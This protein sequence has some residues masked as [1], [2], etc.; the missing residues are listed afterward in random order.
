MRTETSI[1]N[2]FGTRCVCEETFDDDGRSI[3]AKVLRIATV[4]DISRIPFHRYWGDAMLVP[5][6]VMF[7]EH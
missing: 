4:E 2:D 3:T 7:R 5:A 6:G 1:I